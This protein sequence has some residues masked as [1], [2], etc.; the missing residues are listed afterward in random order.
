M[1]FRAPCWLSAGRACRFTAT[2]RQSTRAT[3]KQSS[4]LWAEPPARISRSLDFARALL[5]SAAVSPS[6]LCI[7]L[8]GF[9]PA[10]WFGRTSP[11]SCRLTEAEPLVPSSGSWGNAGMGSPTEFLTLSISEFHSGA[12]ASSLS[13]ILEIG[14]LPQRYFLSPKACAG[15]LRRAEKRGK[16]LPPQLHAALATMAAAAPEATEPIT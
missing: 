4:F 2:S 10:G 1:P 8:D 12:G 5:A 11:A 6:S 15:I 3:M 13:D 16:T 9:A 14:D 7:L